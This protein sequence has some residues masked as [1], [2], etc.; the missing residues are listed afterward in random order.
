[1]RIIVNGAGGKMGREIIARTDKDSVAAA[2]D[3]GFTE[4][5]GINL[6]E[7]P[8]ENLNADVIID[9]SHHSAIYD[10]ANYAESCNTPVVLCTTG[11]TKEELLRIEELAKKVPVFFSANMSMGVALLCELAKKSA[12]VFYDADIEII[13]KHHSAKLD[14]PSGTA[15]M[16]AEAIKSVRKGLTLMLGRSGRHE[17][18]NNEI[19]IHAVRAGSIVGEHEVIIATKNEIITV[20]HSAMSRSVFADGAIAAAKWICNKPSG[21][22]NMQNMIKN[23]D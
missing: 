14:A 11:Q 13:E 9:F 21:L 7:F 10:V 16:L 19:G 20:S 12:E 8:K 6:T 2:I 17:R 22:Y 4:T 1:M 3:K 5:N 18:E 15:L 23:K